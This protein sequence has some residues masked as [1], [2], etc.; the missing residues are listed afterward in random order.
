MFHITGMMYGVLASV[1][2]R[3]HRGA[4]AALGPRTGRRL[5]SRHRVTHWTCIPTM[6]IDL[7]G[8]P[9]YAAST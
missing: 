4:D 6:I 1:Y 3:Q 7:F 5:I 8:S 9:N 2:L